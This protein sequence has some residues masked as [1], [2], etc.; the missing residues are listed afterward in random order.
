M[1]KVREG[2]RRGLR[3]D[4][5]L[6]GGAIL[7]AHPKAAGDVAGVCVARRDGE[8]QVEP[9]QRFNLPRVCKEDAGPGAEAEAG[10]DPVGQEG[11][12]ELEIW[13]G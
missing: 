9:G 8:T 2:G 10:L 12:G 5:G 1:V 7:W 11:S 13:V 3:R 6:T 4:K